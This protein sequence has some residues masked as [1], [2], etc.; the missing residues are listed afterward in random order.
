MI[1][2]YNNDIEKVTNDL[3]YR[4]KMDNPYI[5][6]GLFSENSIETWLYNKN[7]KIILEISP[8]YEWFSHRRKKGEIVPPYEEYRKKYKPI[9]VI[10]IPK[11]Q[12]KKWL[13]KCTELSK[14]LNI[15]SLYADE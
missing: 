2:L 5:D 10:E 4:G 12:A 8:S 1:G 7:S 11:E 6:L 3:N 13:E 15:T 14:Q 9:K